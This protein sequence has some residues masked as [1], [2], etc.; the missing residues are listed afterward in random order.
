MRGGGVNVG[1]GFQNGLDGRNNCA[2]GIGGMCCKFGQFVGGLRNLFGARVFK[3]THA[4]EH[5]R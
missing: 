2:L 3:Q 5:Q 4:I 1:G